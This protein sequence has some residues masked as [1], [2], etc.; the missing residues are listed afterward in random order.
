MRH[1]DVRKVARDVV[2]VYAARARVGSKRA[3]ARARVRCA[4]STVA[5]GFGGS[6][7]DPW[8]PQGGWWVGVS[9]G[10]R[11]NVAP[12][13]LPLTHLRLAS[14]ARAAPNQTIAKVYR[15]ASFSLTLRCVHWIRL[16][17]AWLFAAR[18]SAKEGTYFHFV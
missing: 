10:G 5:L 6:R 14:R 17:C 2:V 8:R 9:G 12:L 4:R 3:L 7:F 18:N 13:V 1:C 11:Y 16:S 15:E